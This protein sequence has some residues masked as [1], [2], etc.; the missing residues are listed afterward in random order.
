MLTSM[1]LGSSSTRTSEARKNI[2]QMR[3]QDN[4]EHKHRPQD[5]AHRC[6]ALA[7]HT[8]EDRRHLHTLEQDGSVTAL[9]NL[10]A[11]HVVD[12]RAESQRGQ[13]MDH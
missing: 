11:A 9:T 2:R 8:G 5:H 12:L 6:A 4:P 3:G 7:T 13:N 1:G 10:E